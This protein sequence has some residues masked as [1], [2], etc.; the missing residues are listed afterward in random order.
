MTTGTS[1]ADDRKRTLGPR[2]VGPGIAWLA[3]TALWLGLLV[4]EWATSGPTSCDLSP[5]SSVFGTVS[6]SWL[7]PGRTC[8]WVLGLDSGPVTVVHGPPTARL[9]TAA[10]LALWGASLVLL[11]RR[12]ARSQ[13]RGLRRHG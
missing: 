5:G 11:G 1:G 7:P 3:A 12:D 9:G 10:V 4:A 6:W 13:R 8:T 2:T